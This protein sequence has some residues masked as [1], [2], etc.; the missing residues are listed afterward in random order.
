MLRLAASEPK[1]WEQIAASN[2]PNIAAA[3]ERMES[4]LK[5]LRES[6]GQPE[7]RAKFEQAREFAKFV[8][9]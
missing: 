5:S 8:K 1:M 2:Q 7:F 3:L 9:S 6:L 4:T